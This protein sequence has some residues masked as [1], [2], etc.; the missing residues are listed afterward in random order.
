[1]SF[2][3]HRKQ[4]QKHDTDPLAVYAETLRISINR[5]YQPHLALFSRYFGDVH[6][7]VRTELTDIDSNGFT[8]Q[9]YTPSA[10]AGD[11]GDNSSR[12][13]TL[14]SHE[15][16]ITFREPVTHQDRVANEIRIL[17]DEA[18]DALRVPTR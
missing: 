3:R 12:Q 11:F 15:C 17:A 6:N 8:I 18:A 14:V 4:L 13:D 2:V 16:R 9:S 10:L 5:D 1:M 7:A